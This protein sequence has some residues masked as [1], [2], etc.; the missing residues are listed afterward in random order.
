MLRGK[1]HSQRPRRRFEQLENRNMF[2]VDLLSAVE[3]NHNL[4]ITGDGHD[5]SLRISGDGIPGDIVITGF[6]GTD[7]VNSTQING[8]QDGTAI[9]GSPDGSI[10]LTGVTG[11]ISINL[12][13][14]DVTLSVTNLNIGNDLSITAGNG[15]DTIDIGGSAA[16]LLQNGFQILPAPGFYGITTSLS[17]AVTIGGNLTITVGNGNDTIDIGGPSANSQQGFQYPPVSYGP[18]Q[19]GYV[20]PYYSVYSVNQG[21]LIEGNATITAG[22]GNDTIDVESSGQTVSQYIQPYYPI[23][24]N[25]AGPVL[26]TTD[27]IAQM[28][29][30]S[31]AQSSQIGPTFTVLSGTV[32]TTSTGALLLNP[33][34]GTTIEGNLTIQ[35]GDGTDTINVGGSS[36]PV[37]S[38][39]V[40]EGIYP[41]FQS[42]AVGLLPQF[43]PPYSYF[44]LS[45]SYPVSIAGNL[46]ITAGN[47]NDTINVGGS[48]APA[49]QLWFAGVGMQALNQPTALTQPATAS[50]QIATS[51][52]VVGI[53]SYPIEIDPYP[54]YYSASSSVYQTT[55]GG[56][57]TI[58]VGDGNDTISVDDAPTSQSYPF[59]NPYQIYPAG[60]ASAPT[61]AG[62]V[63]SNA[64]GNTASIVVPG[65][66][67]YPVY[68]P[69]SS[70]SFSTAIDGSV[71][72]T[73][74]D[75]ADSVGIGASNGL[76]AIYPITYG[77][78]YPTYYYPQ[79]YSIAS[80]SVT[81]GSNLS[82]TLG[83]GRDSVN[84]G[85]AGGFS[86]VVQVSGDMSVTV[87]AGADDTISEYGLSVNGSESI[88]LGSHNGQIQLGG[89]T[90]YPYYNRVYSS[91]VFASPSTVT[92]GQRLSITGNSDGDDEIYE[93]S[94]NVGADESIDLSASSGDDYIV[95]G[96]PVYSGFVYLPVSAGGNLNVLLGSG[97][98][99]LDLNQLRVTGTVL[100]TRGTGLTAGGNI[101]SEIQA[102]QNSAPGT[103]TAPV[104][105]DQ[106]TLNYVTATGVGIFTGFGDTDIV[107][108][109][110]TNVADLGVV[111]GANTVPVAG[112]PGSLTIG[113]T[114]TTNSTTLIALDSSNFYTDL[115]GNSFA[116]LVT[117]GFTNP[118]PSASPVVLP[119]ALPIQTSP[120][121]FVP[122]AGPTGPP[123][124]PPTSKPVSNWTW[125]PTGTK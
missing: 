88:D 18:Y 76:G 37:S 39:P 42:Y 33:I 74:G 31:V 46:K 111:L 45:T 20:Y 30:G 34:N 84:V 98:D 10:T 99:N 9:T 44:N 19:F 21:V 77:Y 14:G 73:A 8:S 64:T 109:Q 63:T 110:N 89:A 2:A 11:N 87:G 24:F 108:I 122:V 25:Q 3:T 96:T 69:A 23:A 61:S 116:N 17:Q 79:Y 38:Y 56:D 91:L 94:L 92:I 65:Q 5:D 67:F 49:P 106:I 51:S 15:N 27:G 120:P 123:T 93:D 81:V 7:G 86:P 26:N 68:Q 48:P 97:E 71:T 35:V 52:N 124:A 32:A 66:L 75:G 125:K 16:A 50:N 36:T 103:S 72:I 1:R 60:T 105:A 102:L 4:T 100:V 119:V 85:S 104:V 59:Y 62:N 101:A 57:L 115:G 6:T 53:T 43:Y 112:G 47:G 90:E 117:S 121:G 55:I 83:A 29:P 58:S 40:Y 41:V 70:E 114:T 113:N 78:Y 95:I 107:S 28:Q 12:G 82:I 54:T 80:N 13:D 118:P 22:G